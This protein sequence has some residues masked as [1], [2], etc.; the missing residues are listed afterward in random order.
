MFKEFVPSMEKQ[1]AKQELLSLR[2]NYGTEMNKHIEKFEEL[3]EVSETESSE[4]YNY[5]F[6][7]LPDNHKADLTKFFEGSQ[8]SDIYLAHKRIRTFIIAD[9]WSNQ[10][11]EANNK[12]KDH[13]STQFYKT[14]GSNISDSKKHD[15]KEKRELAADAES[16]GPVQKGEVGKYIRAD[17]CCKCGKKQY[18]DPNHPCRKDKGNAKN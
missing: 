18:S 9:K 7:T 2:W 12:K 8:P 1:Q 11:K 14:E 3:M 13:K 16:W 10:K 6:L 15:K 17:R 4:A 5:F